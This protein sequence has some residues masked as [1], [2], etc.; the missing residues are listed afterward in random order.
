[1]CLLL[2]KWMSNG[3][4]KITLTEAWYIMSCSSHHSWNRKHPWCEIAH[5]PSPSGSFLHQSRDYPQWPDPN[6]ANCTLRTSPDCTYYHRHSLLRRRHTH[7]MSLTHLQSPPPLSQQRCCS[8]WLWLDC[9]YIY[10]HQTLQ[11]ILNH[12]SRYPSEH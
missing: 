12:L 4:V 11:L 3:N 10:I 9:I 1:M 2:C 6:G 7:R 5:T 8:V